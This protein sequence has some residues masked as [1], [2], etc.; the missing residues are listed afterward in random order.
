MSIKNKKQDL[1]DLASKYTNFKDVV[2]N[3]SP[4]NE[5]QFSA[6]FGALCQNKKLDFGKINLYKIKDIYNK[7][8]TGKTLSS[9][10]NDKSLVINEFPLFTNNNEEISKWGNMTIDIAFLNDSSITFIENKIGSSF[11]SGGNQLV[12]QI[13]YLESLTD[14]PNDN[15][16]LIVLSSKIFFDKKWYITEFNETINETKTNINCYY[17]YWEEIFEATK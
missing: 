17:I 7:N 10:I 4:T 12:K 1:F 13:Q 9:L 14:I 16:N 15:K 5:V 8:T 11:T 6:V 2:T 3:Y